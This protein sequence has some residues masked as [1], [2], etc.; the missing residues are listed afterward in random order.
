MRAG[1]PTVDLTLCSIN[2]SSNQ[3]LL[4]VQTLLTGSQ[5]RN[6]YVLSVSDSTPTVVPT[7]RS[8]VLRI[9]RLP[10]PPKTLNSTARNPHQ[11]YD[12]TEKQLNIKPKVEY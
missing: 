12:E 8:K 7:N 2:V 9:P 11:E 1:E 4:T 6:L 3:T 10:Q 5:K